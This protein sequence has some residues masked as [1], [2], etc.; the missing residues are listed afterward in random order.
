[1]N[2]K[3]ENKTS[4]Y[5]LLLASIARGTKAK[6]SSGLTALRIPKAL[7]SILTW[8]VLISLG[9]AL[10]GFL[11]FGALIL[12]A[13]NQSKEDN[14][15]KTTVDSFDYARMQDQLQ[16]AALGPAFWEDGR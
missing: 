11:A 4:S 8:A 10:L 7:V 12:A 16:D 14:S 6:V 15:R 5:W 9:A 13:Y 1:M 2:N 3:F